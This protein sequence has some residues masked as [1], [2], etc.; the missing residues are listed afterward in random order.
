MKKREVYN[1]YKEKYMNGKEL[2][3]FLSDAYETF[4]RHH[5]QVHSTRINFR[6]FPKIKDDENYRIF[7]NEYFIKILTADN[8]ESLYFIGYTKEKPKWA[9]G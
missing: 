4:G 1:G 7:L 9:K 3:E 2:K 5:Q 8:D 6:Y